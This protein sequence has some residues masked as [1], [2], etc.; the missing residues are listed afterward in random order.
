[1]K[2]RKPENGVPNLLRL[3][4][5]LSGFL[6]LVQP[7]TVLQLEPTTRCNLRCKHCF[8]S[9]K[10]SGDMSLG[11]FKSIV[12]QLGK[13]KLLVKKIYLTGLGEPLLNPDVFSMVKY[14]KERG[15]EVGFTSNFT[16]V[17]ETVA[18]NLIKSGLDH[19]SVSIDGASDHT[20]EQIRAGSSFDEVVENVRL[21]VKAKAESRSRTPKLVLNAVITDLNIDETGEI[22]RLGERL[23]V[24]G[25]C[26][27]ERIIPNKS[28]ERKAHLASLVNEES[29]GRLLDIELAGFNNPQLPCLATRGCYVTFDGI[30]LPCSSLAQLVPREEYHKFM[31]GNLSVESFLNV[32]Y[33]RDYRE[34]RKR[35][36][37]GCCQQFCRGCPERRIRAN[38][39]ARSND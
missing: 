9:S 30:I 23:G 7:P 16:L 20:Y 3:T 2:L 10:T 33:S 24:D 27:S 21:F 17:N 11:L 31:L 19:L 8:R 32:W 25:I 12:N 37:L 38:M 39:Y 35:L 15:F 18:S 26:L 4:H 14:A 29:S 36:I 28:V 5:V 22:I 1:M 6:N 34:F 13:P